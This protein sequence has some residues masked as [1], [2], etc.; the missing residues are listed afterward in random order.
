[1]NLPTPTVEA[2]GPNKRRWLSPSH[3][4]PGAFPARRHSL[5]SLLSSPSQETFLGWDDSSAWAVLHLTPLWHPGMLLGDAASPLCQLVKT[6][7]SGS[8]VVAHRCLNGPLWLRETASPDPVAKMLGF[9]SAPSTAVRG[10]GRGNSHGGSPLATTE[11]DGGTDDGRWPAQTPLSYIRAEHSRCCFPSHPADFLGTIW[12]IHDAATE[13]P[14]SL[15]RS[16]LT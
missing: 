12:C 3:H 14:T 9:G 6:V 15:T 16:H 2:Q 1:M 7:A 8:T 11:W 4:Q 5:Q 13:V 10:L